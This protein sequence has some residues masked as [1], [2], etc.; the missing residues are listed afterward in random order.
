MSFKLHRPNIRFLTGDPCNH[1][2]DV[3]HE[4]KTAVELLDKNDYDLISL[5]YILP[6]K[7]S[8][9]YLYDYIRSK[10]KTTPILFMSGNIEFLE[11]IKD[12]KRDD[13]FVDHIAKPCKNIY[14][15]N[16][17]NCLLDNKQRS[18]DIPT[19]CLLIK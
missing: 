1:I 12:L 10:D 4:G 14:Y 8:G 3:A 2:V 17:I 7:I 11:S 13:P 16:S 6:G 15:I 9:K 19:Y 18:S 5:D